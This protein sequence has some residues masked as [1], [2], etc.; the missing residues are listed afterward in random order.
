MRSL[1]I[2][3]CALLALPLEGQQLRS[4][5]TVPVPK[6]AGL[7]SY[8]RDERALVALGKALF[9]DMQ[10]GSDGVTACATCHFHAG[11]DHRIQNQLVDPLQPFPT[12][13]LL[14]MTYFPF[15]WLSNPEDR[16]STV[17]RDLSMRVGSMGLYRRKFVG[18]AAGRGRK[19][20]KS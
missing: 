17:L 8:V 1:P 6:P 2:V 14:E 13:L 15:R 11:A 9:W 3:F 7:D 19:R 12:N 4:L 18:V 10:T 5:K 20:G 16:G